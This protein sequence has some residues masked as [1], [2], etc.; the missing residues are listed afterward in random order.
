M[1]AVEARARMLRQWGA[2]VEA[3]ARTDMKAA[4][5]LSFHLRG[6]IERNAG[7][8]QPLVYARGLA[9]AATGAGARLFE[10]SR[11]DAL[12]RDSGGWSA[13]ANGLTRFAGLRRPQHRWRR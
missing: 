6:M 4:T 5:S 9:L 2:N 12:R 10:H 8:V 1:L 7:S 13:S 11:V 3:L